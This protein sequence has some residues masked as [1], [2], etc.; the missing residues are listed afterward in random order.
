MVNIG[1]IN[2]DLTLNVQPFQNNIKAILAFLQSFKTS[3]EDIMNLKPGN[4]QAID[5]LTAAFK[6]YETEIQKT[7]SALLKETSAEKQSS[8]AT[9][10]H[11]AA[12][13]TLQDRF[14]QIGLRVQGFQSILGIL[15]GTF[16]DLIA[17]YNKQEIAYAKLTNGLKNVGEGAYAYNKLIKQA[18]EL[19]KI[20]P[21]ADEDINNAQAMLTTFQKNSEEIEILTPRI[22][23]LAAA[24]MKTGD[25][26]MDLQQVAVMLGKVNEETIG[27]LR[28]IGVAF[29]KEQEEKLKSLKGTEQAIY[30]SEIL[31]QNFKGMAETVGN[32]A[33]GKMKIFQNQ[34]GE[35]KE[36]LGKIVSE[37][38]EPFL[39]IFKPVIE[40]ISKAP[41]GVQTLTVGIMALAAAFI[42]LNTS[43]GALPY[44]IGGIITV[45]AALASGFSNLEINLKQTSDELLRNQSVTQE[46]KVLLDELN[47]SANNMAEAYDNIG[48]AIIGMTNAQLISAKKFVEAELA[49]NEALVQTMTTM[50]LTELAKIDYIPPDYGKS[51]EGTW[52]MAVAPQV[53]KLKELLSQ[54]DAKLKY[55]PPETKT[56]TS[57][58]RK[59]TDKADVKA[60]DRIRLVDEEKKKLEELNEKLK[61]NAGDRGAEK[62]ILKEIEKVQERILY[63]QTGERPFGKI[64]EEL[65]VA[66]TTEIMKEEM[67]KRSAEIAE[68]Q[69]KIDLEIRKLKIEAIEDEFEKRKEEIKLTYD[70]ELE[71]INELNDATDEQRD[72]LIRLARDKKDRELAKVSAEEQIEPFYKMKSIAEQIQGIFNFGSNTVFYNFVRALQITEQI[73]NL[74]KT[75]DAVSGIFSFLGKIF[76]FIFG[77]PAAAAAGGGFA[78]GGLVPGSGSGDTVPALLTPGEFVIRKQRVN[79]LISQYGSSFLAWLNGGG[80]LSP[81]AGRYNTGGLV[82]QAAPQVVRVEIV[83]GKL[84]GT[85]LWLSARRVDHKF[86][87]RIK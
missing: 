49:K 73:I 63:L 7:E 62:E 21:F 31:D 55:T 26:G 36:S 57:T 82:M 35:M 40:W 69:K 27:T 16:G 38:L 23:D 9:E 53:E 13:V 84:K 33:A 8:A 11:S 3:A 47:I 74:F 39:N 10:Q 4:N 41:P 20:T 46:T 5:K 32:T 81:L 56:T 64:L 65:D 54:I 61:L 71:R 86:N 48:N 28:R 24:Y 25:S 2:I 19:Q 60:E 59:T 43:M 52:R 42:V 18:G 17:E 29:T 66:K 67:L 14:Q 1:S 78:A 37:G 79:E 77:G 34:I 44:I 80:L 45:V 15:K 12:L 72:K 87:K 76:G 50:R 30:L 22:L 85:D 75:I 58:T 6:A 68:N 51:I 70:I 83:G